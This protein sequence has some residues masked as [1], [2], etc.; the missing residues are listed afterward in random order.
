MARVTFKTRQ[1]RVSFVT[2]PNRRKP[3]RR[4]GRAS[5]LSPWKFA[6]GGTKK[7]PKGT[8]A[9]GVYKIGGKAYMACRDGL[10]H[11]VAKH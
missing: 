3:V 6:K 11:R 4:R 8:Q 10:M 5:L 2:H 1:G 9:G 7:R